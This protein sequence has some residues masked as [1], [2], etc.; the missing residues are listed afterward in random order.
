MYMYVKESEVKSDIDWGDVR[1]QFNLDAKFIHLGAPQFIASHPKRVRDAI[2]K[3]RK[4]LDENPVH[5]VLNHENQYAQSVRIAAANYL[6]MEN[7]NLIALTDSTTM[8]LGIIYNGLKLKAGQEIIISE[9]DHFCHQEAVRLAAQK[10][11]ATYRII[12]L[13]KDIKTVSENEIVETMLNNIKDQTRIVGLTWVHSSNGLKIPIAKVAEGIAQINKN[14]E[15]NERVLL[16]VDAVH[17]FGIETETYE[18]LGC[19]F[20]IAGCHKWLLGPRGTGIVAAKEEAWQEVMPTIPSY[21]YVMDAVTLG[22][23]HP[24]KMDGKQMTPG[25]FHSL[26]HRWAL[27]EAFEFIESIGKENIKTRIY[28]LN[29]MVKD[30]LGSIETVKIR[31]P[32]NHSLS[33]GIVAFEVKGFTTAQVVNRLKEKNIIATSSPYKESFVRFTPGIYNTPSEVEAGIEAVRSL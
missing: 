5:F 6:R 2:V 7:P 15:W 8:G 33:A 26:E 3:Y 12:S 31:T 22:A 18:D 28:K 24:K 14:R 29:E 20:F 30:G 10:T 21:T 4:A 19:D 17:G 23:D 11:G 27:R 9:Y 13:Y 16:I 32:L 25:G 1:S